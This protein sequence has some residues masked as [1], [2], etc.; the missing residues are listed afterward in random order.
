[1]NLPLLKMQEYWAWAVRELEERKVSRPGI[2]GETM[3][4]EGI[5]RATQTELKELGFFAPGYLIP[6]FDLEGRPIEEAGKPYFRQ[7]LDVP[8]AS[9]QKYHQLGGTS[10]HAYLPAALRNGLD[11]SDALVV[12]EGEHKASSLCEA[13]VAAVGIGGFY[14]FQKKGGECLNPEL[15]DILKKK[16]PRKVLFLGDADTAHNSQFANAAVR[17]SRLTGMPILLPRIPINQ[18]KG[19]DDI[20]A[21]MD[22][23]DTFKSFWNA[24]VESSIR[25]TDETNEKDLT[26]EIFAR[27]V[28]HIKGMPDSEKQIIFCK[29]VKMASYSKEP[30]RQKLLELGAQCGFSQENLDS[31]VKEFWK[32]SKE[33]RAANLEQFYNSTPLVAPKP[34]D[35]EFPQIENSMD[36]IAHEIP[37]PEELVEGMLHSNTKSIVA[38]GSKIGKTWCLLDL[39]LSVATGSHFWGR[40]TRK[41]RVLF[42]NMELHRAFCRE[43]L[44]ELKDAR[45]IIEHP[46][47][48]F[49][50]LRGRVT[51]IFDLMPTLLKNSYGY[52]LIILD[53]IY[54]LYGSLDENNASDITRLCNMLETLG[55]KTGAAT[56]F[57]AHFAKGN[58]NAK[59]QIDRMSG[60]GVFARDPDSIITLTPYK[61][62]AEQYLVEASLR[63]FPPLSPFVVEKKYPLFVPRLDISPDKVSEAYKA[64]KLQELADLLDVALAPREFQEAAAKIG[65][66]RRTYYNYMKEA[67]VAGLINKNDAGKWEKSS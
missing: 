41:I 57:A 60:S 31:G 49:W 47:L 35:D 22:N 53:P 56:V 42:I 11:C 28:P 51:D 24:L 15:A 37:L 18:S 44:N 48:D 32:S 19:V 23:A 43:R 2:S 59:A 62:E 63:N 65:I 16:N 33:N 67:K 4:N 66:K 54:K 64:L 52:G 38:G 30:H 25:I 14:G 39:A 20:R 46:D 50:N 1:M 7:R 34:N 8:L 61:N 40:T 10:P 6:Y 36:F 3:D 13:G 21:Q 9:G 58:S 55:S 26:V 17:F 29:L 5:F 27:E 12:V 45:G